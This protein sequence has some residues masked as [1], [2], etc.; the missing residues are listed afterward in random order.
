MSHGLNFITM[1]RSRWA[2]G[3]MVCV[4]LDSD[5]EQLP[6]A[7]RQGSIVEEAVLDF[8]KGIVN[9]TRKSVCAYKPNI[10]FYSR[11]DVN[12]RRALASTCKYIEKMAPD[13]PIILD[14]K[15]A[16]IG[17]TNTGY[18]IEAFEEYGVDAV[19]VNPYLGEEALKPFLEKE[20]RGIIVLCRT[21]NPGAAEFQNQNLAFETIGEITDTLQ[22]P[23]TALP[24]DEW[25][26]NSSG[27]YLVPLYQFVALRV[28]RHWNKNNNCAL[29]VG[30]T[31]PQELAIVRQ[32]VGDMPILVPGVGTQGGNL[33][34]VLD[35]GLTKKGDGLIINSSRSVIFAYKEQ[36]DRGDNYRGEDYIELAQ[37]EVERMNEIIQNHRQNRKKETTP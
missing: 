21:S 18:V 19:T 3:K 12:L 36:K 24:L 17:N 14:A 4:G 15:R 2:E 37:Q 13:V 26:N 25:M 22:G 11:K 33:E 20:D 9:G 29:V 1:L 6:L 35:A 30:A 23:D 32:L 7:V 34:E 10:A 31:A 27:M 8:N 28:A 16:D 5:A